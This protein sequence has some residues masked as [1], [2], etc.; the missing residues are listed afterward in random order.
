MPVTPVSGLTRHLLHIFP[1]FEVGGSQLR[2][3]AWINGL[4]SD[5]RHT[6]IGLNGRTEGR[7]HIDP[8]IEVDFPE[9]PSAAGLLP[10]R[11]ARYCRTIRQIAPD[12]MLTNNWGSIEF[13]MAWRLRPKCRLIHIESGFGPD[14][15]DRYL[16]R[17]V[18]ARRVALSPP[19][20]LVVPSRT[21]HDRLVQEWRF[22]PS[23]VHHIPDGIDCRRFAD[24][25]SP[26][27]DGL[28]NRL[29]GTVIGT[30]AVLRPEKDLKLLIK[31]FSRIKHQPVTLVIAGDGPEREALEREA[32][33]LDVADQVMFCG[34]VDNVE[35]VY[36]LFDIFV[37]SSFTEQTPNAVLQAMAA[38]LPVVS[39][40]VGDV[41]EMLGPSGTDLIVDVGNANALAATLETVISSPDLRQTVG[42]ENRERVFEHF[43]S[44]R[45]ID[46]YRTLMT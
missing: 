13:A 34:H 36:P 22:D 42:A 6:I 16:R 20:K 41:P 12:V 11:L 38:G 31:A 15:A 4:G 8:S 25:S 30:V 44:K 37:L 17:R 40:R 26:P 19:A 23:Q 5:Y 29:Q 10:A 43:D 2:T 18:W 21:L 3:A 27:P 28:K 35:S 14:E 32:M 46:A 39:T 24:A 45:M 9:P 1:G 7:D 33:A